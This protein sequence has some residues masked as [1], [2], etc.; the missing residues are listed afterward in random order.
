MIRKIGLLLIS[1]TLLAG[2][3]SS[4]KLLQRGQYDKAIEKSVKKL[5]KDPGN[6]KELYV[7]KEAYTKANAFDRDRIS[8]LEKEGRSENYIEIY[9]LYQRLDR[10]QDRIKT[11]PSSLM[12]EFTIINYDDELIASKEQAAEVSYQRGLEY[13]DAG[14][15]ES[16]R[17]AFYEF[18]R[19]MQIYPDY[20]DVRDRINEAEYMGTN[21][22]L[23][24]IENNSE[25]ILPERF[26]EELKKIGMA[27]LNDRWIQYSVYEDEEVIYDY[28]IMLDIRDIAISPERVDRES[29]TETAEVQDGMKYV[30][31]ERGN[32]KKDSLGN[33]IR[34]PNMVTISAE[35]TETRQWKEAIVGGSINY[36][37][38][39]TDQL[40]RSEDISVT[41]LF[42]HYSAGFT[43]DERALSEDSKNIIGR[44]MVQFPPNEIMLMDSADL[45]KEKSKE[46]MSRNKG[47]LSS[48]ES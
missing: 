41:A 1:V 20:K 8:F 21:Q 30:L 34:E 11:L 45:L 26:D 14:N 46:V 36:I 28:F 6:D 12:D 4:E 3:A 33:D 39:R 29:Y 37:D 40:V 44:E 25:I 2:C 5:R 24:V 16:A 17:L 47:L 15:R 27:D 9:D 23:F 43:G 42:E 32:V 10:R 18:D 48:T 13:M 38:L 31:D 7:L 19:V 22:V 35:V